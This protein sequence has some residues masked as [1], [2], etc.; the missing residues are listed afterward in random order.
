MNSQLRQELR[1]NPTIHMT[2]GPCIWINRLCFLDKIAVCKSMR[3]SP[4][5]WEQHPALILQIVRVRVHRSSLSCVVHSRRQQNKWSMTQFRKTI[6]RDVRIAK[7][8]QTWT[9][10]VIRAN[11][12]ERRYWIAHQAEELLIRGEI[13]PQY[14]WT[15]H[16]APVPDPG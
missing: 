16:T 12:I 6:R 3:K 13:L 15:V 11:K 4:M 1:C 10:C 8:G 9:L 2:V 14:V 5:T 7:R